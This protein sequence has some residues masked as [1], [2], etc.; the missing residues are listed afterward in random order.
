MKKKAAYKV[1]NPRLYS[2]SEDWVDI[3]YVYTYMHV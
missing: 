1:D 3:Y 2:L